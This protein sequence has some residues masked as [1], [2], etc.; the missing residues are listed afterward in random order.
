MNRR[1]NLLIALGSGAFA[2][3]LKPFAQQSAKPARIGFL[4]TAS[5]GELAPSLDIFKQAFRKFGYIEGRDYVLESR[6]A[7]GH[8][9]HVP[10][11]AAELVRLK[12]D[13]IMAAA[14]TATRAAHKAT[15]TIPI[16]MI[17]AGDPVGSRLVKSLG[18]PGGN[19]TGTSNSLTDIAPKHLELLH[20]ISPALSRL[21]VWMNPAYQSHRD[22]LKTIQAL[23]PRIGVQILPI[24]IRTAEDVEK[25]FSLLAARNAQGVIVVIDPILTGRMRQIAELAV[26]GRLLS[27]GYFSGNA[28]VGFLI[29]YGPNQLEFYRRAAYYVDRILKGTEPGDLPIEQPTKFDLAINLKTAKALGITVPQSLLQRADRVIE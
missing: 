3:P 15:T 26:K 18:R 25:G 20:D 22:A 7:N 12:V 2:A 14:T 21:A 27:V 19:I 6:F 28:D 4:A 16:V 24:E 9:N 11:L 23:A 29:G 17:S 10:G 13:V 8:L 5:E 1:R